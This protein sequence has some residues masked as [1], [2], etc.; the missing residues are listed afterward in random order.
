L[1]A[2]SGA[3]LDNARL[4]ATNQIAKAEANGAKKRSI[5]AANRKLARGD[6]HRSLD[7]L[8]T[9]AIDYGNSWKIVR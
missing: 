8:R 1:D 6:N 7:W 4:L 2:I 3:L 5:K 9:A